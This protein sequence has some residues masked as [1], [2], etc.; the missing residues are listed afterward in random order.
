M[1]DH[2]YHEK[3]ARKVVFFN[4]GG[5]VMYGGQNSEG[6]WQHFLKTILQEIAFQKLGKSTEYV[7]P[8][9]WWS[10]LSFPKVSIFS[11]NLLVWKDATRFFSIFKDLSSSKISR[12]WRTWYTYY[13]NSHFG[14]SYGF[15]VHPSLG[16][17]ALAFLLRNLQWQTM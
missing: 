13:N 3:N 8:C 10:E 1:H 15:L 2:F 4:I 12:D 11:L 14:P 16:E 5:E 7:I 17:K 9:I 6:P